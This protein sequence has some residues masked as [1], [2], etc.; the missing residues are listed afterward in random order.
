MQ[1]FSQ[2]LLGL[3]LLLV[4]IPSLY[5][6]ALQLTPAR[7]ILQK[8]CHRIIVAIAKARFLQGHNYLTTGR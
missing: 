6:P 5:N 8:L 7:V 3:S 1:F 4:A 2:L